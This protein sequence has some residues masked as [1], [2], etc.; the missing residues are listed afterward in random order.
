VFVQI[1]QFLPPLIAHEIH[2]LLLKAEKELKG[3]D[4]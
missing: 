2:G 3:A 4:I 1:A